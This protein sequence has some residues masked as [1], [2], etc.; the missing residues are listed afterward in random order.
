MES[1][2]LSSLDNLDS[3]SEGI[4]WSPTRVCHLLYNL[5]LTFDRPE[6]VEIACC[7]GKA[8][9]YLAAAAKLRNGHLRSVDREE[10]Y[11]KGN[12][13]RDLLRKSDLL[14]TTKLDLKSD[15]RWY[16][17]KLLT[18]NRGMWIDV[19][20]LDLAHTVE[21]DS[22][23]SLALWTHLKPGGI[24]VFDDIDWVPNIHQ[25]SHEPV[26]HPDEK[27]VQVI[28]DYIGGM[29]DVY[30]KAYWGGKEVS[31]RWGFIRK[32]A[33]L[34]TESIPLKVLLNRLDKQ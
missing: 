33:T 24:M 3:L 19:A 5:V 25:Q 2:T 4:P 29:G 12:S 31:W 27:H 18:R 14:S 10:Y 6:V 13:V 15:A 32:K 17:L 9:I 11:W 28:F 23:A 8:T 16:L 30:E 21:I 7:Y 34:D 26:V 22:F 20:F 1:N